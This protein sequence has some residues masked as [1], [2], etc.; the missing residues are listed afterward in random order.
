MR[1][2]R[3]QRSLAHLTRIVFDTAVVQHKVIIEFFVVIIQVI[4]LPASKPSVPLIGEDHLCIV[5]RR[6]AVFR[7][8]CAGNRFRVKILIISVFRDVWIKLV[9][10]RQIHLRYHRL[11]SKFFL[12]GRSFLFRGCQI[13]LVADRH[14]FRFFLSPVPLIIRPL[15]VVVPEILAQRFF[16]FAVLLHALL[17]PRIAVSLS[18]PSVV[19]IKIAVLLYVMTLHAHL[20]RICLFAFL[21]LFC[22]R[23]LCHKHPPPYLQICL[24]CAKVNKNAPG[25]F[26]PGTYLWRLR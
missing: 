22:F 16:I 3:C 1:S 14:V 6:I 21:H 5:R 11:A 12:Y 20:D 2:I 7:P 18:S 23:N 24:H 4:D 19:F 13:P 15:P 8:L 17:A 26:Q 9:V 10:A 25:V